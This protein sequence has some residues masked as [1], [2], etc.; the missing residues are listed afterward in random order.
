MLSCPCIHA[1]MKMNIAK[2]HKVFAR[3]FPIYSFPIF[4]LL[5]THPIFFAP[6]PRQRTTVLHPLDYQVSRRAMEEFCGDSQLGGHP[7]NSHTTGG[8][9]PKVGLEHSIHIETLEFMK[10]TNEKIQHYYKE[11]TKIQQKS[12][13]SSSSS[14]SASFFF[15]FCFFFFFF[16]FFF[17]LCYVV[18]LA[19]Q[20]M[21]AKRRLVQRLAAEAEAAFARK[22]GT[23]GVSEDDLDGLDGAD[24]KPLLEMLS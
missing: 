20:E 16:F 11:T 19:W 2:S 12:E 7:K 13:A 4:L 18:P 10:Q 22:K 3:F 8:F 23:S 9:S 6:L 21:E 1:V 15:F 17:V 14:S 5:T 24:G